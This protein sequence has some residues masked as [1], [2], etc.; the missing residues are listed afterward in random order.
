MRKFLTDL[1]TSTVLQAILTIMVWGVI[2]YLYATGQAVPDT[3]LTA[4]SVILGY[5][6][7]SAA[8]EAL[9]QKAV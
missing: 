1:N 7:H 3:L 4:G 6:F 5:Y 2:S 9:T 8:T